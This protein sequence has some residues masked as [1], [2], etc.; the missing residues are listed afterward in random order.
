MSDFALGLS[1]S[2]L[3]MLVSGPVARIVTFPGWAWRREK[4][5]SAALS[6]T[7]FVGG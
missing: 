7:G 6:F 2:S 4:R 3:A 5:K 1:A